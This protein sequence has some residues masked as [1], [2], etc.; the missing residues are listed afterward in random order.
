[1]NE[2]LAGV[3]LAFTL[4]TREF[5]CECADSGCTQGIPLTE[6]EYEDV[7]DHPTR[8]AV[9]NGHELRQVERVISVTEQFTVVE[10]PLS[11]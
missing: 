4:D 1:M 5:V 3:Y 8:F 6:A 2:R 7:R 11:P 9:A 10:K